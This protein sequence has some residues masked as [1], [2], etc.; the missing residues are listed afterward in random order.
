MHDGTNEPYFHANQL[1][2][3]LDY[4][5]CKDALRQHVN[6][7]DI[8][9]LEDIVKNYLLSFFVFF[10]MQDNSPIMFYNKNFLKIII[11]C[12]NDYR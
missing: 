11:H 3:L 8:L 6:K 2:K 10:F 5:D 1:C 9:F 12:Y 7:D 4:V